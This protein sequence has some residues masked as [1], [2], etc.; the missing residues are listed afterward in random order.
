VR[1]TKPAGDTAAE[2]PV[3]KVSVAEPIQVQVSGLPASTRMSVQRW[4]N[5]RWQMVGAVTS[6]PAGGVRTPEIT[7]KKPGAFMVRIGSAKAGW[8]FVRV[9][10]E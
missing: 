1:V 8:K 7:A 3:V 6:G 2:A 10:A 9:V 5:G 4:V